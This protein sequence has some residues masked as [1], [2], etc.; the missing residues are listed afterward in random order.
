[1]REYHREALSPE[2]PPNQGGYALKPDHSQPAPPIGQT[3][4]SEGHWSRQA[5]S[6]QEQVGFNKSVA[7]AAINRSAL[8]NDIF[9]TPRID[10]LIALWTEGPIHP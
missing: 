1:M 4:P 7:A 3:Y 2:Q 9:S 5:H 6:D 10:R 8:T